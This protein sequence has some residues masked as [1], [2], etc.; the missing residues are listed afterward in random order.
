MAL[1]VSL[2]I[3]ESQ[4]RIEHSLDAD[5]QFYAAPEGLM[6]GKR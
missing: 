6:G 5:F 2:K 4:S 1:A 3:K